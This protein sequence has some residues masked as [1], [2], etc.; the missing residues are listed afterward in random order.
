MEERIVLFDGVIVGFET[1]EGFTGYALYVQGSVDDE[2]TGFY[3]L[4]PKEK[5]EEYQRLGVGQMISGRGRVKSV[6]PLVIELIE[7]G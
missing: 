4:I 7:G 6:N 2:S 5:Y 1:P 3:V